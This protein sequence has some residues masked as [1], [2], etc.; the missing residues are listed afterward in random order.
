ML[1][2]KILTN[3]KAQIGETITWVIATVIIVVVLLLF[4]Y[5]A[6][7]LG[8]LNSVDSSGVKIKVGSSSIDWINTKTQLAENI[9]NANL[10]SINAWILQEGGNS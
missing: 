7:A 10:N 2:N 8:K 5:A 3:K 6:I 1:N 4:I 9:N